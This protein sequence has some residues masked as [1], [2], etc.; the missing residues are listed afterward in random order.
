MKIRD[1]FVLADIDRGGVDAKVTRLDDEGR[2][3]I[4]VVTVTE[5][6]LGVEFQYGRGTDRHDSARDDDRHTESARRP[7]R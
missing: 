6:R 3:A 1:T 5:L 4:S 2:H 7:T